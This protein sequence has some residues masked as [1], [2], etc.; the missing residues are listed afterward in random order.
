[1]ETDD[2]AESDKGTNS[3]DI[4]LKKENTCVSL[5]SN[6]EGNRFQ[7]NFFSHS[8]QHFAEILTMKIFLAKR[9]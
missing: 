3:K 7:V 1:M 2:L 6:V 4:V 5:Y 8:L 9:I